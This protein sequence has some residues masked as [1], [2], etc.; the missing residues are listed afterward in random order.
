MGEEKMPFNQ[1]GT[2]SAAAQQE[3][4]DEEAWRAKNLPREKLVFRWRYADAS[5]QLYE[6]R[7]RSLAGFNVG[8]AVQA[9]VRSRLEWMQDN[10]LRE[11]PDGVLELSIDPEGDVGMGMRPLSEPPAFTPGALRWQD[12][13]LAGCELAGS[14]WLACGGQLHVWPGPLLHAADTFAR[15]LLETL[16]NQLQEGPITQAAL[17]AEGAELFVVND[18]FGV[19]ACAGTEGPVGRKLS[20]CFAKL[21]SA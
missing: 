13:R 4:V 17:A 21:W 19:V 7:L 18:E 3:Q 15:D 9:W 12:G 6:R 11:Q 5:I 8:P 20:A 14:V 16:G 1:L 2:A 10:R